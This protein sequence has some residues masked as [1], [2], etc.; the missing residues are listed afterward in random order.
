MSVKC[1]YVLTRQSKDIEYFTLSY[2]TLLVM[3][4]LCTIHM[5]SIILNSL[6]M[7]KQRTALS[8][9]IMLNF[10][11]NV[12]TCVIYLIKYDICIKYKYCNKIRVRLLLQIVIKR[13]YLH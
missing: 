3:Y 12:S 2:N 1:R 11:K 6:K 13:V 9:V 8:F 7:S 5:S 4:V 10:A